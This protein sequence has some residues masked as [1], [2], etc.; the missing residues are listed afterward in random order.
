MSNYLEQVSKIAL[1]L[2]GTA[3]FFV[4]V[5][6]K[7]SPEPD[8]VSSSDICPGRIEDDDIC[9][10]WSCNCVKEEKDQSTICFSDNSGQ[11]H[12]RSHTTCTQF[13]WTWK[14][15]DDTECR[16]RHLEDAQ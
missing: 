5:W 1:L 10:D 15:V 11:E 16:L 13:A 3:V 9:L 2:V 8:F 12:C 7:L 6:M 14:Y 4:F